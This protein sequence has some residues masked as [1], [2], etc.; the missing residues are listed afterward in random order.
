MQVEKEQVILSSND[1][2]PLIAKK[3]SGE[4]IQYR[5]FSSNKEMDKA[6]F[7]LQN[8]TYCPIYDQVPHGRCEEEGPWVNVGT[9]LNP[10]NS[11]KGNVVLWISLSS[12]VHQLIL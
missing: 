2:Y 9:H 10:F 3:I 1:G 6:Y 5:Y 8:F 11:A 4:W 7:T 12:G